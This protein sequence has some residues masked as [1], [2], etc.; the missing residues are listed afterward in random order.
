MPETAVAP[1]PFPGRG[2]HDNGGNGGRGGA[3]AGIGLLRDPDHYEEINVIGNGKFLIVQFSV[4]DLPSSICLCVTIFNI[5]YARYPNLMIKS[6]SYPDLK[7]VIKKF[8][9]A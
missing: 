5:L 3:P 9:D 4:R 7:R 2:G 1:P 6:V 8:S